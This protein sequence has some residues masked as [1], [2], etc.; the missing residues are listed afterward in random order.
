VR[1]DTVTWDYAVGRILK[2]GEDGRDGRL[3]PNQVAETILAG[4]EKIAVVEKTHHLTG[5]LDLQ[6]GSEDQLEPALDF[7][8]GADIAGIGSGFSQ[9]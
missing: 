2:D 5:R 9:E 7:L 4:Q 6:E 8:V 1:G 3:P